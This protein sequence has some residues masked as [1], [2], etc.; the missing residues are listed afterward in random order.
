MSLASSVSLPYHQ[1]IGLP[2]VAMIE[3]EALAA[4]ASAEFLET[5]GFIKSKNEK[6]DSFGRLRTISFTYRKQD[7]N[8]KEVVEEIELPLMSL[9]PIPLLQIKDATLEFS[10]KLTDVSQEDRKIKDKEKKIALKGTY[11]TD[12]STSGK[13]TSECDL[14]V[15]INVAQSDIPVGLS[16]LFQVFD[17]GFNS[18]AVREKE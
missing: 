5:V 15:K 4:R 13:T 12:K 8:D 11:S 7:V 3:A 2:L 16:K 1:L 6:D 14:K 17:I 9:L 10:L 18:R